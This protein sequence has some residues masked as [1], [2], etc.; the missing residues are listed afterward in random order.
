MCN[1]LEACAAQCRDDPVKQAAAEKPD[2][3]VWSF[4]CSGWESAHQL[5]AFFAS[6]IGVWDLII[7]ALVLWVSQEGSH[8]LEL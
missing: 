1:Q 6:K 4:L 8:G 5:K 2:R 3:E 7:L